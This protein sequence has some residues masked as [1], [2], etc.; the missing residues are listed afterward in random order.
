VRFR[1]TALA[2]FAVAS[3]LAV[4]GIVVVTA[5]RRALVHN[6]DTAMSQRADDIEAVLDEGSLPRS[7]SRSGEEG[8]FAQVVDADGRVVAASEGAAVD[9]ALAPAP[10]GRETIRSFDALALDDDTFRVLSRRVDTP[11]GRFVV[12]VAHSVDDVKESVAVLMRSLLVG[13]PLVTG[14]LGALVWWLTGRALRPVEAIRR[15]VAAIG[16]TELHRRVPEPATRD[17]IARLAQT[18]NSMLARL[19]E[20]NLRQQRFV[21]DASHELRSPITRI[22][23]AL[24][25]DLARHDIP[26]EQLRATHE[27]VLADALELQRLVD[28]L[29]HLARSDAGVAVLD[30]RPVD[31]DDLVLRE[32]RRL[33]ERNRVAV[34]VG[35]VS[36]AQVEGD[37]AELARVIRNLAE[38]AER[39]ARSTVSF[40]LAERDGRAVLTVTDDGPGIDAADSARI[41]ERFTRLDSARTPERG[42]AGLGLAIVDEI[43]RRHRGTVQVDPDHSPGTCFV[44][45][46]PQSG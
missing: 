11:D 44:V 9:G 15:E 22:R 28:D 18:M 20:A 7:L 27:E 17:E 37:A 40:G 45:T 16:A 6:V 10:A 23:S 41:F 4:A 21:A 25:V 29:L 2:T 33:R 30:A 26:S 3:I 24:E 5:Q 39:H 13:V 34:D 31:L 38:N 46:L 1:L 8:S 36:G 35:S 12:H 19:E 43:V 32:A 14:L 42:G